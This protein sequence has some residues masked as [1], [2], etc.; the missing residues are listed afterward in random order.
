MY[1]AIV[2]NYRVTVTSLTEVTIVTQTIVWAGPKLMPTVN[3]L[4]R[5]QE[6]AFPLNI[7]N[8][9]NV[10]VKWSTAILFVRRAKTLLSF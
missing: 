2:V 6:R 8:L 3:V 9:I 4:E 1:R 5:R 10:V 7:S